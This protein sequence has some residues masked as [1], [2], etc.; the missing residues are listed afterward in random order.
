MFWLADKVYVAIAILTAILEYTL[1]TTKMFVPF[2]IG[3]VIFTLVSVL[4][5]EF[6]NG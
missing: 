5:M 6:H 3:G 1:F 2:V 4:Y